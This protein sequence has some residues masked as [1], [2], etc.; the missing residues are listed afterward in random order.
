M[1]D[2]IYKILTTE[3]WESLQAQG[4]SDGAPID[5]S[6]GFAHFSNASQ[7]QE[8]ADKHFKNQSGL[9]LIAMS[10]D[11]LGDQLRWEPSRGGDLFPHLYHSLELK[12]VMWAKPM[13]LE[14]G[15]HRIPDL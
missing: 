11:S 4:V 6:D 1:N 3:Q 9:F 13:P 5:I 15:Q 10:T 12:N 14:N 8:T 2:I 7:L